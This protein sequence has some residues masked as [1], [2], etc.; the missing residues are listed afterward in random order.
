[1][2]T[3]DGLWAMSEITKYRIVSIPT[4]NMVV[5]DISNFLDILRLY[6]FI[7]IAIILICHDVFL[8]YQSR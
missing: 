5:F 1:M 3:S 2:H 6:I 4:K 8:F 7:F